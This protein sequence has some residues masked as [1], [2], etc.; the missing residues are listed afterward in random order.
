MS[1]PQ[2]WRRHPIEPLGF[3]VEL[4]ADL[5]VESWQSATGEG[6]YQNLAGTE[7]M[8]FVHWGETASYQA[9]RES[10]ADFLTRIVDI[11][12][13]PAEVLGS[14]ARLISATVERG[15][16]VAYRQDETGALSHTENPA[17]RTHTEVLSFTREGLPVQVGYRVGEPGLRR[18]KAVFRHFLASLRSLN[19]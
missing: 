14:P 12:E 17:V 2:S 6:I 13:A 4:L 1:L 16:T 18:H 7:G 9:F 19:G 15:A 11:A 10:L 3:S 8:L 5:P